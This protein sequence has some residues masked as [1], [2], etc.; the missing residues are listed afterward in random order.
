MF[1]KHV[2]RRCVFALVGFALISVSLSGTPARLG[3][4]DGMLV[5]EHGRQ[6]FLW[7]MNM[8]E[9]SSARRH[10]SWHGPDDFHNLRRWGMNAVRLLI[11]WSAIEPEPGVYDDAYLQSVDARVGWARDAGLYVILD[12]HQDLWSEAIPGGNG[13]PA[14]ATLDDGKPHRFVGGAWSTAYFTSP[15]VQRAFD[16]FWANTPGPDGVG[17]QDRFA[18]AWQH[19]AARYADTP[20]VAGFDI[21]NEPFPGSPIRDAALSVWRAVPDVFR[22]A[23]MPDGLRALMNSLREKPYPSWL[24]EALDEPERHRRVVAAL[25]PVTQEFERNNLMPMYRRVHQ[26][27]REK[28]R[29]GIFFLEP[30]VLANVGVRSH[31]E[32]LTDDKG[33]QDPLQAYMPHAYDIVVDTKLSHQPSYNRLD[34]IFSQ[35]QEDAEKLGM[36]LLIGEWGAFY[37][38]SKTQDAARL[39]S[40]FLERMAT[41]AF[42]WDYHRG[43]RDAVYFESLAR[44]APLSVAGVVESVSFDPESSAFTCVWTADPTITAPSVFAAPKFWS[45]EPPCVQVRPDTVATHIESHP[46]DADTVYVMVTTPDTA[47]TITLTM[48]RG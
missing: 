12:M 41:G 38:N 24:L 42:Y 22:E 32:P 28:H 36:P 20:T 11:F 5:D 4:H 16:N 6:I 31:I 40:S 3:I 27:I 15:R 37:G 48:K 2:I 33:N 29:D 39:K 7:G 26:A 10:E 14:W 44:P 25:A 34:V 1:L 19:V 47:E 46:G 17:I 35:K 45:A 23:S 9:K 21:M 13:A 30:S 43:I 8:G 18:L